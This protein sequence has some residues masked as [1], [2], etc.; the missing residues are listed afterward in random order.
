VLAVANLAQVIG[1]FFFGKVSDLVKVRGLCVLTSSLGASLATFLLWGLA[2]S[3]AQLIVFAIVYGAFASGLISLWARIGTFFGE[4][5]A[6][7]IYS[8]MSFGRGIGNIGSGPISAALLSPKNALKVVDRTAYGLG[9]YQSVVLFVG[10]CM[11]VSAMLA[12]IGFVAVA[13]EERT[14]RKKE[15]RA[16]EADAAETSYTQK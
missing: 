4:K 12:A 16:A 6:Q 7:K 5:D 8:V 15:E 1:E 13:M 3:Y 11:S 14:Q 9:K 10:A 2:R